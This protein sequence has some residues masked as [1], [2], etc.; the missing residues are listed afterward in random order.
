VQEP[1]E[2]P[3][4]FAVARAYVDQL[5]RGASL[6]STEIADLRRDLDAAER[7]SGAARRSALTSLA[8]RVDNFSKRGSDVPR[9]TA[10]VAAIRKLALSS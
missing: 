6:A 8:T 2:W 4:S 5:A 10:L 3:A 9:L 1:F 7:L